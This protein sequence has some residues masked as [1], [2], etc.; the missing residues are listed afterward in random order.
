MASPPASPVAG[1]SNPLKNLVP[2]AHAT[3]K[4]NHAISWN[5]CKVQVLK[6]ALQKYVRRNMM[7]KAVQVGGELDLFKYIEDGE[8]VRS[9]FLHRL[10]VIFVEDIGVAGLA[11]WPEVDKALEFL[12]EERKRSKEARDYWR[13]A[14]TVAQVIGIL[15]ACQKAR[16]GSHARA[17]SRTDPTS[18]KLAR[19]KYPDIDEVHEKVD[20]ILDEEG[21]DDSKETEEDVDLYRQEFGQA[22]RDRDWSAV[23]WAWKLDKCPVPVKVGRKKKAVWIIFEQLR[24]HAPAHHQ[25]CVA[26]AEKWFDGMLSGVEEKFLCWL[27]VV[28][29]ILIDAPMDRVLGD[30]EAVKVPHVRGWKANRDGLDFEFED[31]VL[32]RHTAEGRG[33][34]LTTFATEGALVVNESALVNR[35]HEAFY[36][37]M[38][39][40]QDEQAAAKKKKK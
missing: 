5:G 38:K 26:L 39:A 27:D 25:P 28:V 32:D 16:C 37:D 1:G 34:S 4:H 10:A 35:D 20:G 36:R 29:A 17:I 13:E 23:W 11:L 9:N 7:A 24:K 6:S 3:A 30:P 40:L 15:C 19:D 8:K 31:F 18:R 21:V 22:L 12:L 2:P 14:Q 33:K